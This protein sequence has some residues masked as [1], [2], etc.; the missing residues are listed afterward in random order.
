MS[1]PR[2]G[3]TGPDSG[4]FPAWIFTWFAIF[5]AGG[6]AVRLRPETTPPDRPLLVELDGVVI[7]GGADVDPT[8]YGF[9]AEDLLEEVDRET[10][11]ETTLRRKLLVILF[12]PLVYLSRRIFSLDKMIAGDADRDELEQRVIRQARQRDLP[13]LGICRGAQLINVVCGGT[14]HR[15]LADFYAE[16]PQIQ[17]IFPRKRVLIDPGSR[18]ARVMG[19]Q[20]ALVNALHHQA[21]DQTGD[22]IAI[23]AWE[24]T[25]VVQAIE[26]TQAR[27]VIGI[28]WH[29]EFLPYDHQHRRLFQG[30]CLEARRRRRELRLEAESG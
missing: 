7:G 28:Q 27:F 8:L 11:R 19:G 5:L 16:S 2:I 23:C 10:E 4:G 1:R 25:G 3:V 30:L 24:R 14:L 6:W 20:R 12:Y 17:S 18:L 22:A 15:D 26:D 29:P 21:V 9:D 13:I